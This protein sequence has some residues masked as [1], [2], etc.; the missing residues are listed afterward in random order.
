MMPGLD[1]FKL[2]GIRDELESHKYH[3][4]GDSQLCLPHP[5]MLSAQASKNFNISEA[6]NKKS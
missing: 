6:L 3:L 4:I 1:S 2:A 5:Y